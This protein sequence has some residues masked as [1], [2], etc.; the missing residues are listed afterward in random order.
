MMETTIPSGWQ[1]DQTMPW[2]SEAVDY[3]PALTIITTAYNRQAEIKK[4]YESLTRQ[5]CMDFQW[6][7]IDDGSTDQTEEWFRNLTAH[8]GGSV[9]FEIEYHRKEN[10]GKHTALNF[11]H[12]YIKGK[13]MTIVDSD[14]FLTDDA[15]ETIVSKW[16]ELEDDESIGGITFQKRQRGGVTA[17]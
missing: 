14:D 2:A 5:T 11:S 3:R 15:V 1:P 17:Q 12:P 8:E 6:L 10:G 9:P 7:V 4:L 13:W 16:R